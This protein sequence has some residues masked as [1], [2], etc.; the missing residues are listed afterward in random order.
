LLAA[1][2]FQLLRHHGHAGAL[3]AG[4]ENGCV[5]RTGLGLALLPSLRSLAHALDY[6]L[7]MSRRH[8]DAA[9]FAKCCPAFK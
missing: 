5:A 9:G 4:V 7:D 3:A 1:P 2:P 6:P 8:R